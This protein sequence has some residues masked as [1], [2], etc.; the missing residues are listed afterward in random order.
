M[1]QITPFL[2]FNVQAEEAALFYT[3][4]FR[5]SKMGG[6]ARYGK[7]APMP[8]GTAMTVSFTVMGMQFIGLNGGPQHQFT[9]ATSFMAS[10]QNQEEIDRYWAALADGGREMACGWVQ[11]R[12]GLCWQI[13]PHN[14]G[15]LMQ[16]PD[17]AAKDRMMQALW[18]MVK[19]DMQVLED[20]F[21]GR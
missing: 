6:I 1:Q 10:C 20:A 13:I 5:D 4:L 14:L 17:Q 2:W 3:G 9:P 21:Y 15:T 19:L 11:D 18:G 7:N 8:E 12:Y 16:Q